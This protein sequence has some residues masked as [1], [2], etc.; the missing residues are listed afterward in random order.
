MRNILRHANDFTADELA[1][2]GGVRTG[3]FHSRTQ[4]AL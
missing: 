2:T 3:S 1:V 4:T